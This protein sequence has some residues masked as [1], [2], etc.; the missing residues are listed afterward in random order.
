MIN[1]LTYCVA[2]SPAKFPVERQSTRTRNCTSALP[3][4]WYPVTQTSSGRAR[5][6]LRRWLHV[7]CV[8]YLV[9]RVRV[10]V[11]VRALRHIPGEQ[12]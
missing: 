11:R 3:A 4:H 2:P 6:P 10:R 1:L 12:G 5:K 9:S 8:T 7:P